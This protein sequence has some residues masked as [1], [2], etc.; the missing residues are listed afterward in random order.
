MIEQDL[1][2]KEDQFSIGDPFETDWYPNQKKFLKYKLGAIFN[3]TYEGRSDL[4]CRV[5]EYDRISSY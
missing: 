3:C 5:M 2:I 4:L 1:V